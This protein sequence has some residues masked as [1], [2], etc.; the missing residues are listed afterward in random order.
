M[1]SLKKGEEPFFAIFFF[2]N[3]I[4]WLLLR[5]G[6]NWLLEMSLIHLLYTLMMKKSRC[7]GKKTKNKKGERAIIELVCN[8]F[9]L[10]I[11]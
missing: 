10:M 4:F 2:F 7:N 8:F 6:K 5:L 3:F 11:I 9:L 1:V